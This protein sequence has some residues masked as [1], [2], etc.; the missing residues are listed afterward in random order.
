MNNRCN[1]I[2]FNHWEVNE[3]SHFYM[4]P[5]KKNGLLFLNK[6][7]KYYRTSGLIY[8]KIRCNGLIMQI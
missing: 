5:V 6:E 4:Q 2:S 1:L 3:D 7:N 8:I